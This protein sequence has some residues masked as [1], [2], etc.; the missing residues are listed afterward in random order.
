MAQYLSFKLEI[1]YTATYNN[2]N[3][4]VIYRL[5]FARDDCHRLYTT[6]R[7]ERCCLHALWFTLRPLNINKCNYAPVT[8]VCMCKIYT[9]L[10]AFNR[11]YIEKWSKQHAKTSCI[12]QPTVVTLKSATTGRDFVDVLALLVRPFNIKFLLT[13]NFAS[14][15]MNLW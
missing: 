9:K 4:A 14:K 11:W 5:P 7:I 15:A 13:D 12:A 2:H 10:I 8:F 1:A 3:L 6:V